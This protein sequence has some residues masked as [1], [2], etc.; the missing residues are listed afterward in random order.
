MDIG[1]QMNELN[2]DVTIKLENFLGEIYKISGIN[3]A[4]YYLVLRCLYNVKPFISSF[5]INNQDLQFFIIGNDVS[6]V[7]GMVSKVPIVTLS[8]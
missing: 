5:V 8:I 1:G 3:S 7:M 2:A 4:E 6:K